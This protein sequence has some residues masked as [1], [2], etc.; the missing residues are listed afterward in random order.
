MVHEWAKVRWGVYEEHGYP[1]DDRF[2]MYYWR[3]VWTAAGPDKTIQLNFCV[4]SP[5]IGYE[6]VNMEVV[7]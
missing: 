7:L 6:Q 2:P 3:S 1:G 4:N 5:L